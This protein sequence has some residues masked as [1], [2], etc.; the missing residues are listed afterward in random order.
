MHQR[1]FQWSQWRYQPGAAVGGNVA[2]MLGAPG[3]VTGSLR[4]IEV[5]LQRKMRF[6]SLQIV[7]LALALFAAL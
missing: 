3:M 7:L 2:L 4:L 6:A 1:R 5:V